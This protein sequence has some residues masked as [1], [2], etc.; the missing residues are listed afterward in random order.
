MLTIKKIYEEL[1]GEIIVIRNKK[2]I[3]AS[4]KKLRVK[5]LDDEINKKIIDMKR[6]IE[7]KEYEKVMKP[8]NAKD[9]KK[10]V[11]LKLC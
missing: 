4:A 3:I 10:T 7:L 8:F 5:K 1:T 2:N 9:L 6:Y 11:Q